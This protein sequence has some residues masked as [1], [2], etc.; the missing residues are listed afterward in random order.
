M[1][2][3]IKTTLDGVGGQDKQKRYRQ[4]LFVTDAGSQLTFEI[5][6]GGRAG[7]TEKRYPRGVKTDLL[8]V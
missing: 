8:D 4:T 2:Y 1:F 3:P 5:G 6:E 7:I